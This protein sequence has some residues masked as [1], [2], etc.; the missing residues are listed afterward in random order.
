MVTGSHNG[1]MD[2]AGLIIPSSAR[3]ENDQSEMNLSVVAREFTCWTM[4]MK[5]NINIFFLGYGPI[6]VRKEMCG[7][8][9]AS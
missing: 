4:W 8:V 5:S 6:F 1:F 7:K 3:P 2:A 9:T